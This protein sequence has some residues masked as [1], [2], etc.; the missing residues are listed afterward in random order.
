M[1][2]IIG[3]CL[4]LI[5]LRYLS[6]RNGVRSKDTAAPPMDRSV[7]FG[8]RSQSGRM[9]NRPLMSCE[10]LSPSGCDVVAEHDLLQLKCGAASLFCPCT[11]RGEAIGRAAKFA[12]QRQ[13]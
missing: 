13:G 6:G 12:A 9:P 3:V 11:V 2:V 5:E 1:V 4:C 10:M 8:R 7:L